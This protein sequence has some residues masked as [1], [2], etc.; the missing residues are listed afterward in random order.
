MAIARGFLGTV[1]PAQDLRNAIESLL[2]GAGWVQADSFQRTTPNVLDIKVWQNPAANNASG[3]DFYVAMGIR[4]TATDPLGITQ[5][6]W[7]MS[8][9]YDIAT[10]LATRSVPSMHQSFTITA[11]A[12][13]SHTSPGREFCQETA[14]SS[15]PGINTNDMRPSSPIQ[16]TT[17]NG[18][19]STVVTKDAIYAWGSGTASINNTMVV[20]RQPAQN[21]HPNENGLLM[22]G[23]PQITPQSTSPGRYEVSG[24]TRIPG[25]VLNQA[26]NPT[27]WNLGQFRTDR[28]NSGGDVLNGNLPRAARMTT[29]EFQRSALRTG[30][31]NRVLFIPLGDMPTTDDLSITVDG[32]AKLYVYVGNS[33]WVDQAAV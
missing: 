31:G 28:H 32:V 14:G 30:W 8:E 33:L 15:V 29:A 1:F 10:K 25:L 19:Y 5:I 13:G 3:Q 26:Y 7:G 27:F 17:G 24:Y 21:T 6:L 18:Y 2:P 20:G 22:L 16:H 12:V 23:Q 4:H 11:D 9:N